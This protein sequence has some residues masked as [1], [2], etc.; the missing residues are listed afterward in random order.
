[1][2]PYTLFVSGLLPRKFLL[3]SGI[4][5]ILVEYLPSLVGEPIKFDSCFISYSTKDSAF[6]RALHA[7]LLEAGVNAWLF[8]EDAKWGEPMWG[9]IDKSIRLHDRVVVV[10]SKKSLESEPVLR[11]IERALRRED[12][13]RKRVLFPIRIDNYIF[14][15]WDHPRKADVLTKVV[16]D[17]TGWKEPMKM[18]AGVQR[19]IQAL[20][21]DNPLDNG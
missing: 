18:R 3:G 1:M 20:M 11:E 8:E 9:E 5:P 15:H 2:D 7:E 6:C 10:C 13:E 17:F 4:P 19:L 12:S 21:R 16:G 14:D